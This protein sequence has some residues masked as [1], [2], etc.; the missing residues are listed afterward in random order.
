MPASHRESKLFGSCAE[1]TPA[2]CRHNLQKAMQGESASYKVLF[3]R[4]PT[5]VRLGQ[6]RVT[7]PAFIV[8]FLFLGIS[9]LLWWL[10]RAQLRA[11]QHATFERAVSSVVNRLERQI[12]EHEQVLSSVQGLYSNFVQ[13]V[14]DVF[15]LYATVPARS[16]AAVLS[17]AYAPCVDARQLGAYL[18]YARSERYWDYRIFP[19]ATEPY[20]FP[21]FYIVPVESA[22]ERTGWNAFSDPVWREVIERAYLTGTLCATP[23]IPLRVGQ[24]TVWGFALI[25]PVYRANPHPFSQL[26]V[27]ERFVEGVVFLE[28]AGERLLQQ[29]LATPAPTDSLIVFE[30]FD[31]QPL[32][33][34]GERQVKI[35]QSPNRSQ[36]PAS[37]RSALT[38]RR[39]VQIGDRRLRFVFAATP[40]LE[41]AFQ[42]W[43]PWLVLAGGVATSFVAFGFVFSLLTTRARALEL[44]DRMTRAQR[45]ILEASRD[46]IAVWELDGRWRAANPAVQGILGISSEALSGRKVVEL[47]APSFRET[48]LRQLAAAP[49]EEATVIEVPMQGV[50]GQQRWIGWNLTRSTR[51]GVIYAIGRDIT[52]QK[53]I[54]RH[55]ELTRRQL[56]LAEQWAQEANE[57]KAEFLARLSFQLRN[58]LTG[59]MGFAE[60]I[61]QKQYGSD[62]ELREYA[63]AIQE[64]AEYLLSLVAETPEAIGAAGLKRQPVL[65]GPLLDELH[66]WAQAQGIELQLQSLPED[67]SVLADENLLRE[68]LRTLLQALRSAGEAV[69]M[70]LRVELNPWEGGSEW[71]V[72]APATEE[73]C[74]AVSLVAE[75]PPLEV[76]AADDSGMSFSLLLAQA[77]LR[78]LRGELQVEC[79]EKTVIAVFTLPMPRSI[80]LVSAA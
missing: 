11:E 65:L 58:G 6:L 54:E 75:R 79:V 71:S 63:T 31:I 60:L 12:A 59:L 7:Y 13:V 61:A 28:L 19:S 38:A 37:Y 55:Q 73:L 49:E 5:R 29:A 9:G 52:A 48:F 77:L 39:E 10:V 68:A 14:R 3:A 57:F 22:P 67:A 66:K 16:H 70:A 25:A 8:L 64:S 21:V 26:R 1:N 74:R 4:G 43:I 30:G 2:L 51:D 80:G 36:F 17:I 72:S 35:A 46:I 33:T 32:P 47:V 40:Q 24:D 20:V 53:E 23:W 56:L 27:G 15:E 78:R 45:R 62:A 34:G 76:L 44:A 50:S 42:S 18:H 69:V 41:R